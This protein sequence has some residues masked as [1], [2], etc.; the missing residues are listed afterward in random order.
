MAASEGLIKENAAC[1]DLLVNAKRANV[2]R[3]AAHGS[4]LTRD[5]VRRRTGLQRKRTEDEKDLHSMAA[6]L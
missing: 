2:F 1:W 6:K 3:N 4:C 5:E